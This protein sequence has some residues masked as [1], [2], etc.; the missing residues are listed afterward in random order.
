MSYEERKWRMEVDRVAGLKDNR[1]RGTQIESQ[2]EEELW[3]AITE[4]CVP[5]DKEAEIFLQ[6]S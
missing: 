1:S 3:A 4:G 5:D 2:V 6:Q